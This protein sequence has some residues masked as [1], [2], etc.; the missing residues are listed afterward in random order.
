MK[1]TYRGVTYEKEPL[2]LEVT[3]GEIGGTYRGQAWRHRYPRHIPELKPQPYLQYRGV[4][5][6]KRPYIQSGP[7]I[8]CQIEPI[9][10][11]VSAEQLS[12][13]VQTTN[14]A[15]QI[16]LENIRRHLEHRLQVAKANDDRDLIALLQ[17][18]SQQ[19]TLD[20]R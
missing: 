19:L 17:Q 6:S 3:E 18:E 7:R 20:A 11:A 16:H 12:D 2:S 13:D 15:K 10:H 14:L 8:A 5:Y 1:Y 9:R 4:A